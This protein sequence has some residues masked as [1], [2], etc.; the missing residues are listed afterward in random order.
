MEGNEKKII[1]YFVGSF[2]LCYHDRV[3]LIRAVLLHISIFRSVL[4]I[5]AAIRRLC[6]R[7]FTGDI[8]INDNTFNASERFIGVRA[9]H[10][11]SR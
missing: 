8:A 9:I 3:E 2:F 11:E 10:F 7:V 4:L 5:E 1:V 6:R